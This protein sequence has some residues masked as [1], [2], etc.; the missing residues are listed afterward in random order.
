V[1][2]FSRSERVSSQLQREI[3]TIIQTE[4][5]DPRLGFVTVNEARVARD[6]SV[7]KVYV[8]IIKGNDEENMLVLNRAVPFIRHALGHRLKMRVI[9]ELKFIFDDSIKK[10]MELSDL[11]SNL[12]YNDD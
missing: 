7:A 1:K 3:A 12:G 4:L 11:I 8:S 6:L 10:G 5:K 9:P 2:E